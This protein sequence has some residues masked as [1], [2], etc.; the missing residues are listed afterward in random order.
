MAERSAICFAILDYLTANSKN[1][2]S[3][4]SYTM[5]WISWVMYAK[6]NVTLKSIPNNKICSLFK[7]SDELEEHQSSILQKACFEKL[8]SSACDETDT[9]VVTSASCSKIYDNNHLNIYTTE[10]SKRSFATEINRQTVAILDCGVVSER[11]EIIKKD[12][13]LSMAAILMKNNRNKIFN[14]ELRL[15]TTIFYHQN[16]LNFNYQTYLDDLK[17]DIFKKRPLIFSNRACILFK[18]NC[19]I[20]KFNKTKYPISIIKCPIVSNPSH[21]SRIG[22]KIFPRSV[23][24]SISQKSKAIAVINLFESKRTRLI[25]KKNST[26]LMYKFI[27]NKLMCYFWSYFLENR[28]AR[29]NTCYR[30]MANLM[31]KYR[32]IK[33]IE[34]QFQNNQSVPLLIES[35]PIMIKIRAVANHDLENR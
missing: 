8:N 10:T 21:K 31:V 20:E 30:I 11:K 18:K 15:R 1:H 29:K 2:I 7:K 5:F 32:R 26:I 27:A 16:M 24:C 35:G 4:K 13:I 9:N 28:A 34:K 17:G 23:P 19:L 33:K 6:Q 22:L 3:Q 25:V 12:D 14:K